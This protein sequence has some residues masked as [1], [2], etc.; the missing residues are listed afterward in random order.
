M[1][2]PEMGSAQRV[3]KHAN[4]TPVGPR[5]SEFWLTLAGLA[6]GVVLILCGHVEI[7]GAVLAT[8]IPGYALARGRAKAGA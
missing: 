2:A 5:T 1:D 8:V 7:G 3:P 6:A 4:G